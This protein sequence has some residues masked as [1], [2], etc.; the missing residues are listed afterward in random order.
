[1][2]LSNFNRR[3]CFKI[4]K[5]KFNDYKIEGERVI[6]YLKNRLKET[7]EC[8][9]D[10]KNLQKL[11]DFGHSWYPYYNISSDAYYARCST[12]EPV[13]NGAPKRGI[14]YMHHFIKP[15]NKGEV[16]DHI[17]NNELNNCESNLRVVTQTE[18]AKNRTTKNK[19]NKSG[20]RNVFWAEKDKLWVV[21]LQINKKNTRMGSFKDV[22]EAGKFAEEMR[23]K[24]Y[25]EY[26][27]NA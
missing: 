10:L 24:Y 7:K 11:I 23:K 12:Y 27:G 19:N 3:D 16:V 15:I 26:R 20:Y 13:D 9:I 2:C 17:D 1:M 4:T 6:V 18:N 22:H 14:L 5:K 8:Y 25:G 21:Y